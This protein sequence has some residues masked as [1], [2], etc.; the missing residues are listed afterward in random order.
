MIRRPPRSTRTDTLFPY[1]TLFRSVED[2]A[3]IAAGLRLEFHRDD[4]RA[5]SRLRHREAADVLARDQ[6]GQVFGFLF[7]IAPAAD[8]VDAEVGMR[9]VAETDR[10]RGAAD[11]LHRDDVIEIA[12][13]EPAIFFLDGDAVESQ[14]IG[15]A[16][17]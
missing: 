15:R 9:A 17:V 13:A 1:T 10:S 12:Q 4:V 5:R 8:L 14:Q 3:I 6:P 11:L 2:V 7:G 16:H